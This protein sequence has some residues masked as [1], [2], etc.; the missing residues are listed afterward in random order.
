MYTKIEMEF[1]DIFN[2]RNSDDGVRKTKELGNRERE[3]EEREN[4]KRDL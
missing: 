4:R 1:V 2:R 3:R